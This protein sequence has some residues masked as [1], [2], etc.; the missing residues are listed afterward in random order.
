MTGREICNIFKE[1]GIDDYAFDARILCEEICGSFDLDRDYQN[2]KLLSA[3]N[4][5]IENIP[6]Q[7]I[8]GKWWFY[9]CVFKVSESCL[10]PRSD[11]E[12]IVETAIKLIP[13]NTH[14]ADLCAGS[15]CIGISVL[16]N[17]GDLI[18]DAYELFPDTLDIAKE[19]AVLN[20]VNER[21]FSYL[22]NVLKKETLEGKKYSVI[23]SNPPYIR[24]D[25]IPTLSKEVQKEPIAAL[26][27]G[28]DGLIFYNFMVESFK[29]NLDDDGMFIFEIGYDQKNDLSIIAKKHS[30][31]FSCIKDLSGNDRCVILKKKNT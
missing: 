8:L 22:G 29:E 2:E 16:H 4:K 21:Y 26:D 3:I 17:R 20:G 30:L 25:V 31:E 14:F 13:K 15:G 6:I 27:G 1:H 18:C 7:Y 9:D 12:T 28:D 24:S 10:I 5:R 23:I 19:N 11:T